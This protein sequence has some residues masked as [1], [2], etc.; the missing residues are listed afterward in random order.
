MKRLTLLFLALAATVVTAFAEP[1]SAKA[2]YTHTY[3]F[4]DFSELSVSSA[5]QVE[6]TFTNRYEV[7]VDVPDFLEPY[8]L[9]G[10]RDEKLLIELK[11]IPDDIQRK[12]NEKSGRML[13]YVS[14]PRL[15]FLHLNGAASVSATGRMDVGNESLRIQLNGA[16]ELTG[17]TAQ[18]REQMILQLNGASKADM[19][20]AFDK[21][22]FDMSGAAKLRCSTRAEQVSFDCSGA[23]SAQV[24][25]DFEE[26]I[27]DLSGSSKLSLIGDNGRLT[28]EQSGATKFESTGKTTWA[29]VELTGAAK[30]RLTV[31]KQLRYTLSGVAALRVEDLGATIK[32]DCSRGSKIE[33]FK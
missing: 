30:G 22:I 3:D 6:L 27:A 24:D 16:T 14:M 15:T 2:R 21:L 17:L 28:L 4:H 12:L 32:G 1:E 10:Q 26:V 5:F 8:L 23:S 18:G 33:F 20:V 31:T 25:G 11:Q 29:I 9:V 7:R 19:E 13:A